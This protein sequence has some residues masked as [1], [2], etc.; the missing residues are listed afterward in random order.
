MPYVPYTHP[1]AKPINPLKHPGDATSTGYQ[2]S[3]EH[4]QTGLTDA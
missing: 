3:C 4:F 1:G 2:R